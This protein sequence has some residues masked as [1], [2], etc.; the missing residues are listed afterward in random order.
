MT[1]SRLLLHVPEELLTPSAQVGGDTAGNGQ[2]EQV[3]A[4]N[5]QQTPICS[6][7]PPSFLLGFASSALSS[8]ESKELVAI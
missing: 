1:N 5:T 2:M 7:P 6:V 3:D 4:R 8:L